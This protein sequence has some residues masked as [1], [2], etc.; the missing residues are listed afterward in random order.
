MRRIE[1]GT[2]A[3]HGR[4]IERGRGRGGTIGG[5]GRGREHAYLVAI[6]FQEGC[7]ISKG[8]DSNLHST[9]L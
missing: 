3:G 1:G 5:R 2:T 4:R 6:A 7:G 8:I 9:L